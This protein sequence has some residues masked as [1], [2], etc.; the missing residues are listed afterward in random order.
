MIGTADAGRTA[1]RDAWKKS[2]PEFRDYT[3]KHANDQVGSAEGQGG[4]GGG[5]EPVMREFAICPAEQRSPA[6]FAARAGRLTG[7]R[8]KDM[9]ATIK[10]GE[11][12]KR[13]DLRTQL[14]VERLTGQPQED[15][16]IND[17]MQWGIDHEA[18]AFAAYE[19]Q[20]GNLVRRTGFLSH[21]SLMV[22]CSL[23]G[24]VEDFTGIVEIK[25][26]KSATHYGYLKANAVPSDHMPQLLHNLW[27]SG[28]QW[29]DFV[30]FDPR[31]PAGRQLFVARVP[32]VEIDVLAYAKCAQ[33]FLDEVDAE[34]AAMGAM[35]M[36]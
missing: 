10:S 32:R 22:G 7:S 23:D 16:Y 25:C 20:S 19:A 13:R 33:K 4:E 5:A 1:L 31:F 35:E 3:T 15:G 24:D 26:P 27:V 36:A 14:V 12:A 11:A 9:L 2:K 30:S 28:A 8:A 18:D 17:V 21:A 34:C 6:W 29:C